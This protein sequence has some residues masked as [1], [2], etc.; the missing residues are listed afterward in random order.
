MWRREESENCEESKKDGREIA[1]LRKDTNLLGS[2][3]IS[4]MGSFERY[5]LA[6]N[7][8]ELLTKHLQFLISL[9]LVIWESLEGQ[10][11][12]L[13]IAFLHGARIST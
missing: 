9:W 12:E 11:L 6:R 7:K 1:A 3:K 13:K 2:L 10:K 8:P 4:N 5:E